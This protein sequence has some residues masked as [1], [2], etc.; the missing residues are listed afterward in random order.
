MINHVTTRYTYSSFIKRDKQNRLKEKKDIID[1]HEHENKLHVFGNKYI[2]HVNLITSIV[3][4]II[5]KRKMRAL[6]P[7]GRRPSLIVSSTQSTLYD[8]LRCKL[9]TIGL[10]SYIIIWYFLSRSRI[11]R[12]KK[13]S[14]INKTHLKKSCTRDK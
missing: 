4:G 12:M 14:H 13:I 8:L 7:L 9:N 6:I 1:D 10:L 5:I 11:Y 3:N 2:V